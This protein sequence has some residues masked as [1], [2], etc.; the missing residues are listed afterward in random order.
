MRRIG[1][2]GLLGMWLCLV[3][4]AVGGENQ[5]A[6]RVDDRVRLTQLMR[7]L[8]APFIETRVTAIQELGKQVN[9]GLV[10]EFAVLD[11]LK[12]IAESEARFPRERIEALGAMVQLH[13][14]GLGSPNIL[15]DLLKLIQVDTASDASKG[16]PLPVQI[17]ALRLMVL[18][19]NDAR[20]ESLL[21]DRAFD[22]LAGMW[23]DS[24]K[25]TNKT[26]VY[27]RAQ[28]IEAIS[29]FTGKPNA[30]TMLLDALGEKSSLIRTGALNGLRL[31]LENNPSDAD[32]TV[33]EE[34]QKLLLMMFKKPEEVETR[35][36]CILVLDALASN[37]YDFTK[38]ATQT[39]KQIAELMNTGQDVEA[40]AAVQFLLRTAS[41]STKR[42][43]IVDDI[44]AAARNQG[45]VKR[46]FA[47][48]HE[49]S[50][51]LVEVMNSTAVAM[52]DK[53]KTIGK[54]KAKETVDKII[55]HFFSILKQPEAPLVLKQSALFGLGTTPVA[56]DRTE[57]V[58]TLIAFLE[59]ASKAEKP[60]LTVI[61][62]CEKSL[63]A[64][65]GEN[66][67]RIRMVNPS[68]AGTDKG[69][70]MMQD[71]PE[72]AMIEMPDIEAWKTWFETNKAWLAPDKDPL[73]RG[74]M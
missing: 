38:G 20:T 59:A 36:S 32:K 60:P 27:L 26:P 48:L 63:T 23:K 17:A 29:G 14:S 49:F 43:D 71:N 56:F 10:R 51:A 34:T 40:R 18:L 72:Q 5:D 16:T 21:R 47:T 6:A 2:T 15:N 7:G 25:V 61:E 31:W 62:E 8:R 44:L 46:D 33:A 4:L 28:M 64:L 66:P 45:A 30:K 54:V 65:T 11:S 53:T 52:A 12:E 57:I 70:A 13:K 24:G 37:G 55:Q 35:I 22:G 74:D 42:L 58:Q 73:M 39:S 67:K 3:S 41:D 19:A 1:L 69:K 68:L 9:A 50:K